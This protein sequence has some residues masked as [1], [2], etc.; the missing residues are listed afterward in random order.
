[1]SL[2]NSI[3]PKIVMLNII[4]ITLIALLGC[5]IEFGG[6]GG[7]GD[8][9]DSFE[10]V[11]GNVTSIV[12]DSIPVEG[13]FV[14]VNNNPD[15][16]DTLPSSGF[17]IIEGLFSG[18]S[19]RLDFREQLDPPSF[20]TTFLNVYRGATLELGTINIENGNVIFIN[21]IVTN[22]NGTV[23]ENNCD[24][25]T[26]TLEV[27][28]RDRNPK[29]FVIV[30][31]SPTTNITGCRNEPCFCEDIGTKVKVR[32]ILESNNVVTAGT[33]TIR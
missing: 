27:Q 15:L 3:L 19:T 22:F 24:V 21:Q 8:G 30:N 5:D 11:Q 31:I 29:V 12:P 9:G 17:F 32:G 20:A 28:T 1:M 25:N 13:T 33:L 16:S 6:G 2:Q 14:V 7:G 4:F 18:S 10:T 26:G 23:I